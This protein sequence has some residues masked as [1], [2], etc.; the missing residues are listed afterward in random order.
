M[1]PRP[2]RLQ[3]ARIKGFRLQQWSRE[4]NGLPAVKVTRPGRYGNPFRVGEMI[5]DETGTRMMSAKEAVRAY[6]AV[7]ET[8][9]FGTSD[10]EFLEALF[11]APVITIGELVQNLR[12]KNLACWC[13]LGSPCHADVLLKLVNP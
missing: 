5:E 1:T 7:M 6:S 2:Q 13:G 10:A 3:L 11:G 9:A 8:V 4:L 12:G